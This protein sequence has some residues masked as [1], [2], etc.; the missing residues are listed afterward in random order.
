MAVKK[1]TDQ[2]Q[3]K[4]KHEESPSQNMMKMRIINS[5]VLC[6]VVHLVLL[7]MCGR[8]PR[9]GIFVCRN[10][11]QIIDRQLQ[12]TLVFPK[13]SNYHIVLGT[14]P[15][16]MAADLPT[17]G[18]ISIVGPEGTEVWHYDFRVENLTKAN[19]LQKDG[20]PVALV[21]TSTED[22]QLLPLDGRI[23]AGIPYSV[24]LTFPRM[25]QLLSLW[26]VCLR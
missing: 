24:N 20:I 19:W 11:A 21:L 26:L 16:V 18:S 6:G 25:P 15:Q 7:A 22:N 12:E 17:S 2:E 23:I 8:R 4:S 1:R 3:A 14:P 5:V 9:P 13:G 10:I